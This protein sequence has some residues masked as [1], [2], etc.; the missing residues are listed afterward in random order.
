M[1]EMRRFGTS[2]LLLLLLVLGTA[3]GLRAAYLM[4]EADFGRTKIRRCKFRI[5]AQTGTEESGRP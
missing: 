1:T 5:P 3:G 2:D 4:A